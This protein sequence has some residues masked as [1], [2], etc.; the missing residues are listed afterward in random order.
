[1]ETKGTETTNE[2]KIENEDDRMYLIRNDLT[3]DTIDV[4][5]DE[6]NYKGPQ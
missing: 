5:I 6:M 3:D 4:K 2:T 1:M